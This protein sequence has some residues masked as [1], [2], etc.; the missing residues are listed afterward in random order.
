V[1][2]L[3]SSH[4]IVILLPRI[5]QFVASSRRIFNLY[6]RLRVITSRTVDT[7]SNNFHGQ[8]SGAAAGPSVAKLIRKFESMSTTAVA[9]PFRRGP[10][11]SKLVEKYELL[12]RAAVARPL[13]GKSTTGGGEEGK[14][15]PVASPL[16]PQDLHCK[17]EQD[18]V[19]VHV[20]SGT[21]LQLKSS[22]HCGSGDGDRSLLHLRNYGVKNFFLARYY[23]RCGIKFA[24]LE[25]RSVYR[26]RCCSFWDT[27]TAPG[28][29]TSTSDVRDTS[30]MIAV[31]DVYVS[32]S[33]TGSE[34]LYKTA[35]VVADDVGNDGTAKTTTMVSRRLQDRI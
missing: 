14:G 6:L 32:S 7:M 26:H 33:C 5:E 31:T 8:D 2:Y 21:R 3:C 22:L 28:T 1:N 35:A 29:T 18:A 12:S 10:S 9:R 19:P 24:S 27:L 23:D 4:F 13:R 15:G 34:K 11:V 17:D 16:H 20:F 30:T 25:T